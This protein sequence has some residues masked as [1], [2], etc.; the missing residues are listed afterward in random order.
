MAELCSKC[1]K[2]EGYANFDRKWVCRECEVEL[3]IADYIGALDRLPDMEQT[4]AILGL[5]TEEIREAVD[6]S[7]LLKS[8]VAGKKPKAEHK[9]TAWWFL[10]PILFGIFG[11][12]VAYAFVH[13]D[14]RGMAKSLL[15]LGIIISAILWVGIA[16]LILR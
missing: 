8:I 7:P 11:G 9:N 13:D 4:A 1:G 15:G 3:K 16:L 5:S 2:K 10:V 6:R 14:D 12:L